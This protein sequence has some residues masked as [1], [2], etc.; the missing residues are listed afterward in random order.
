MQHLFRTHVT[1]TVERLFPGATS[2]AA[3]DT[4]YNLGYWNN[5]SGNLVTGVVVR[6]GRECRH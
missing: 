3:A 2:P 5:T 4:V 6:A 1:L